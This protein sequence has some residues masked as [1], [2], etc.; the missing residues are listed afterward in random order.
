MANAQ[1][2][3]YDFFNVTFPVNYVAHV[4]INRPEKMNAFKEV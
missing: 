3:K 2:Y 4:E 1:E